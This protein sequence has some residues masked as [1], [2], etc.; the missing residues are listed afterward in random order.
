MSTQKRL[1][2]TEHEANIDSALAAKEFIYI[3]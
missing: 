3:I 2:H 1:K